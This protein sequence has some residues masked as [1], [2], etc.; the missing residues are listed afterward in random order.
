MSQENV[1]AVRRAHNAMTRGDKDA[2]VREMDPEVEGVSRVMAAE[3]VTYRGHDG[4]RRFI[5][6]LR[7]VFPN[8]RSEVVRAVEY[9][10]AVVAELR[11]SGR[12]AASGLEIEE[13]AWQAVTFRDG[14]AVWFEAY[15]S[16]DE[17]LEAVG[18]RE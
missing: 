6:D 10:G 8:F 5:D 18:L 17:A 14:K 1:E 15:G 2:F 9:G 4:M 11:F 3:G 13:R 12:A 7:S 16:E